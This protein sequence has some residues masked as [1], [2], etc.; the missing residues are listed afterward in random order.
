[1]RTI[2]CTLFMSLLSITGFAQNEPEF[3]M[4]PYLQRCILLES[5]N[6]LSSRC[7]TDKNKKEDMSTS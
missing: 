1:M 5:N 2:I 3:E 7:I 6:N 4:E